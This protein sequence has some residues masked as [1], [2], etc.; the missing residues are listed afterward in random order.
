[1]DSKQEI[2]HMGTHPASV[3]HGLASKTHNL[4]PQ[5]AYWAHVVTL[6]VYIV[7]GIGIYV[8]IRNKYY[9]LAQV[10]TGGVIFM[11]ALA[12]IP[13]RRPGSFGRQHTGGH[14]C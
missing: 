9:C 5:D 2:K 3:H 12:M 4:S 7:L 10:L 6:V 1:M 11:S 13:V 14:C 8:A